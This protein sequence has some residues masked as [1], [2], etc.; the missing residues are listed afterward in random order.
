M[1]RRGLRLPS[2]PK[3]LKT[4][5][6]FGIREMIPCIGG[7]CTCDAKLKV[8]NETTVIQVPGEVIANAIALVEN[9]LDPLRQAYGKPIRVNSGY[10]CPPKNKNVG[11]V[12]QSQHLKGEAADISPVESGEFRVESLAKL[13]RILVE[14]GRFYQL[15]LYPTFLHVSYKRSGANRGQILKKASGGYRQLTADELKS[16]REAPNGKQSTA[17]S[18]PTGKEVLGLCR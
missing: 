4:M 14:Q 3:I 11:G 1:G 17:N 7:H 16:L 18:Q 8:K 10:R 2:F 9:V 6:Y 15:I 5:R 13:A 12:A